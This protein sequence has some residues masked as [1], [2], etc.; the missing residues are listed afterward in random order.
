METKQKNAVKKKST[1]T[2]KYTA[3]QK[4]FLQSM[5]ELQEFGAKLYREGKIGLY[6]KRAVR[7]AL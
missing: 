3:K 1:D 6:D 4:K 5:K 7:W 2:P